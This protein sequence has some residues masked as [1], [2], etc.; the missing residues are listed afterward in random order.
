[1]PGP[2]EV[3]QDE[4][5]HLV[6]HAQV[7]VP[8][9]DRGDDGVAGRY[10]GVLAGEVAGLTGQRG[11]A[12][13]AA[14]DAGV[15][16]Q[17]GQLGVLDRRRPVHRQQPGQRHHDV[18]AG[19]GAGPVRDHPR[20]DQQLAG[21]LERVVEPLRPSSGPPVRSSSPA[22]IPDHLP[23]GIAKLMASL[24]HKLC[25]SL[26]VAQI[27]AFETRVTQDDDLTFPLGKGPGSILPGT[28][29][30]SGA[31]PRSREAGGRRWPG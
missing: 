2:V 17:R 27:Y 9:D 1:M 23:R 30:G 15:A 10:P 6:H 12:G 3:G 26:Y 20:P 24:S 7:R 18:D 8:G 16:R 13:S 29:P 14:G 19:A 31:R 28:A 22:H 11:Q 5:D 25:A 21:Q 4:A